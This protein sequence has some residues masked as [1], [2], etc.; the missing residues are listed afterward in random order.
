MATNDSRS[1]FSLRFKRPK[2]RE[3]LRFM[4]KESGETMNE[5]VETAVEHEL[6]LRGA[7]LEIRLSEA[8]VAIRR[9]GLTRD[10]AR[11]ID[12]IAEGEVSGEDPFLNIVA[13][14]ALQPTTPKSSLESYDPLGIRAAFTNA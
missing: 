14:H 8:L 10:N 11:F 1:V 9:Y 3:A 6:A 2:N 13:M 5:I 12:A 4:A 7:A